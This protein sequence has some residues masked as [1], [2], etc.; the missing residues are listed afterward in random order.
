MKSQRDI[1]SQS[2]FASMS[3]Q[4]EAGNVGH[5]VN[6]G[7]IFGNELGGF[8][9]ESGHRLHGGF[10]PR[11]LCFAFLDGGRDD[12]RAERLGEDQYVPRLRAAIGAHFLWMNQA[13]YRISE[14]SFFVANAVATDHGASGLDHL[15]ESSSK[16]LLKNFEVSLFWKA[17]QCKR[18]KRLPAHGI[19]IAQRV[20]SCDLSESVR[21]V[22]NWR[23][24]V[25]GLY[26]SL[27][28]RDL[29]HSGVV[30][31]VE[32]DQNIRVMLPC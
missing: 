8:L 12:S 7:I 3:N 13:C 29:I 15:G 10:N 22:H 20:G 30:G 32:A 17:Y 11:W 28:R 2:H 24:K 14:F 16:N 19:N 5:R 25:D 23:E 26:Q 1:G 4:A 31:V 21:I 18:S 6:A 9:I 27:I